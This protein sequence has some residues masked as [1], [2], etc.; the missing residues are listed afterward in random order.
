MTDFEIPKHLDPV[1][2]PG[3]RY[4]V[5]GPMYTNGMK[6]WRV[7]EIGKGGHTGKVVTGDLFSMEQVESEVDDMMKGKRSFWFA[8][9]PFEKRA[10]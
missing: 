4:R 1:A 2:R 6:V 10:L 9:V 5:I 7:H 3:T 8:N